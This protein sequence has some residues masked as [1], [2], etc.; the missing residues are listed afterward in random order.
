MFSSTSHTLIEEIDLYIFYSNKCRRSGGSIVHF[1]KTYLCS[2]LTQDI[3]FYFVDG[4][5][6][7]R[8]CAISKRKIQDFL[9]YFLLD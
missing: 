1:F 9:I 5:I 8:W 4:I 2:Y 6:N 3:D 7:D